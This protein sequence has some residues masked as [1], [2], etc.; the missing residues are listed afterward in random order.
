MNNPTPCRRRRGVR[1]TRPLRR[2]LQIELLESRDMPST[3]NL[4][5]LVHVS[6][7][8]PFLGN[9]V[10]ANDPPGTSNLEFEPYLAVDPTDSKHLVTAWTQDANRGIVAGVS[11]DGGNS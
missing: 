6:G 1:S 11:S 7:T 9:P 10:E 5:P 3:F 2:R 8:S 4:T